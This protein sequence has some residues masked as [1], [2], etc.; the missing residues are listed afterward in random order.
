[1]SSRA[2][3]G[4]PGGKRAFVAVAIVA[5]VAIGVALG[6]RD[7]SKEATGSARQGDV[8][9]AVRLPATTGATIDLG[10]FR[11]KRNVLL[12]FYEHAG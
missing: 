7:E 1:M 9:P 4:G 10:D 2:S 11:G 3:S 12:Y 8:A 6:S 5:L